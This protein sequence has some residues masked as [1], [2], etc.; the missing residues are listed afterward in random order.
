MEQLGSGVLYALRADSYVMQKIEELL[1]DVFSM[2][3]VLRLDKE[4]I[5]CCELVRQSEEKEIG[6]R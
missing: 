4:S 2:R 6:V 1:G 5:V 3:S